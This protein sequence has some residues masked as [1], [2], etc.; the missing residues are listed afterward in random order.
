MVDDYITNGKVARDKI[1]MDIKYRKISRDEIEEL[2]KDQRI[3]ASFIG[4]S[5][6]DKRPKQEWNKEYLGRLSCAVV[7]EAFNREYLLYLDEVAGFVSKA[8]L[9]RV[10]VNGAVMILVIIAGIVVYRYVGGR[11]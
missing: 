5:Y 1:A 9:K 11:I 3:T 2:C 6:S 10:I 4:S 8:K 7:G